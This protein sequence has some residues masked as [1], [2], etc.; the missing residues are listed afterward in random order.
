MVQFGI[1]AETFHHPS[2]STYTDNVRLLEGLCAHEI[3]SQHTADNLKAAY[4]AYRN[5]GHKQV[6]Q[7]DKAVIDEAE[8]TDLRTHVEQIWQEIME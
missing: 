1:L 2:L 8:V 4:C 6:L 5:M 7:G 3:I